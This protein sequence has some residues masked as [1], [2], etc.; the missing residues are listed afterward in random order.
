MVN[1]KHEIIFFAIMIIGLILLG[2]LL[3]LTGQEGTECLLNPYRYS[4]LRLND[5]NPYSH[6]ACSCI[7]SKQGSSITLDISE[8][9]LNERVLYI[10]PDNLNLT[11]RKD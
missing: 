8:Q 9:G 5:S 3:Y 2:Y 7:L 6:I 11:W 10:N 1:K 4:Y